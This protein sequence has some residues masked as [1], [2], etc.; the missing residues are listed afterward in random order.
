MQEK[1]IMDLPEDQRPYEK[2]EAYGAEALSDA[3]LLA[4][5]LRSGCRHKNSVLLSEEILR[6]HDSEN[7]LLNLMHYSLED[8]LSV[9]GIG[10]V[11]ALQLLCIAEL[12]RRIWR[13]EAIKRLDL[14]SAAS[15]ADFYME[16]LRHLD[17]ECVCLMLLDGRDNLR[18]SL[19]IAR[20]SMQAAAVSSREIFKAALAHR[21]CGII[22]IHNHPSGDPSPSRE[23]LILTSRVRRGGEE[24]GILLR[25]H[26][27][28]GDNCYFSFLERD[29][30]KEV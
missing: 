9:R 5:I 6:L 11:K 1:R 13:R 28:I 23:D 4:V 21:A 22:L 16:E 2:C 15:V 3:E 29:I 26:V 8:F 30:L 10:R 14:K 12:S 17:Y 20:G 7:G 24:L 18:K 27:I 25:D 19:C